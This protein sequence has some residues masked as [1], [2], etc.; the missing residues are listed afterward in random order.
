M[1]DKNYQQMCDNIKAGT[2]TAEDL[3]IAFEN[4]EDAGFTSGWNEA[5]KFNERN[6]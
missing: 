5:I 4:A 3:E 6:T 1:S 2:M